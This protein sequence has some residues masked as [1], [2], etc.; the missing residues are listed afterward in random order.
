MKFTP[1][2]DMKKLE[3]ICRKSGSN[4]VKQSA[5]FLR[6]AQ[7]YGKEKNNFI[8]ETI[9]DIAFYAGTFCK[10]HFNLVDC[11]VEQQKHGQGYGRVLFSRMKQKCLERNIRLIRLRT[12]IDETAVDF[13]QKMGAEIVGLKGDDY[14]MEIHL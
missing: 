11:A 13:W 9:D 14:V 5:A 2:N 7:W 12:S 8:A 3:D 6:T 4:R 10:S 1:C